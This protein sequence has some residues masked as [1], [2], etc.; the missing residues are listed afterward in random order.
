MKESLL[1]YGSLKLYLH[2]VLHKLSY[3]TP[4]TVEETY[5]LIYSPS[6]RKTLKTICDL[7]NLAL[8]S[9]ILV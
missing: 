7:M 1:Q 5:Q 9:E 4:K 3:D 2:Y 6:R 8:L